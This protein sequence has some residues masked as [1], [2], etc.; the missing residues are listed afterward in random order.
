MADVGRGAVSGHQVQFFGLVH[1]VEHLLDAGGDRRGGADPGA[2]AVAAVAVPAGD[3]GG[4]GQA[5]DV[6]L[7]DRVAPLGGAGGGVHPDVAGGRGDGERLVPA[8]AC[9]RGVDRGPG[10]V[11]VGHLDRERR[12]VRG[13][14]LNAHAADLLRRTEVDIQPLRVAGRAGPAGAGVAVGGVGRRVVG[15]VLGRGGRGRR[16]QREVLR[17][18]VLG[19]AGTAAAGGSAAARSLGERQVVEVPAGRVLVDRQRLLPGRQGHV[20]RDR[21]PGLIRAGGGD[22]DRAGQV[23]ARGVVDVQRVG[24]GGGCRHPEADGVRPG[25][26]HLDGVLEPLPGARPAD[27]VSGAGRTGVRRVGGGLEVDA[28]GAVAVGGAVGRGDVVGDALPA[29]VVVGGLHGAGNR[30]GRPAERLVTR[31]ATGRG[32]AAPGGEGEGHVVEVPPVAV[33]VDRQR[34]LPGRQGDARVDRRPGLVPAGVGD[35]DRAAQVGPG[36]VVDVRRV[37]D[38]VRG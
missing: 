28:V 7:E 13:L 3:R 19:R 21:G 31:A 16:V 17:A 23:G 30:G 25:R 26:G 5:V 18:A 6:E 34:L 36:G 2:G 29:G 27:V 9:G 15:G 32:A 12:S 33:L 38:P 11:V 37:R 4:G 20:G 24:D 35:G 1:G 8:G 10:R 22:G 14:P